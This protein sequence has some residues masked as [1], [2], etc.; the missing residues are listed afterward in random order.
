MN[1]AARICAA[2]LALVATAA[3]AP[4]G[5]ENDPASYALRVEVKVASGATLHRVDLPASILAAARTPDL[6]DLRLFDAS[7]RALP[8]ARAAAGAAVLRH[9]L[10]PLPIL[11]RVGGGRVA[12]LSLRLD[13]AG[14]PRLA[15][16]SGTDGRSDTTKVAGYLFD[17]RAISGRA[18]RLM[19]DA[20]LP[21]GQPITL[22]VEVG[23][24]LRDWRTIGESVVY[25]A[26]GGAAEAVV[27]PLG[28]VALTGDY[29]RLSW[30]AGGRL[31]A[32]VTVRGATLVASGA[33]AEVTVDATAPPLP[34]SSAIEFVSPFAVPI[35]SL[36]V[37]P[38]GGEALVPIRILGRNDSEQPWAEIGSGVAGADD[39]VALGEARFHIL[40]IETAGAGFAALPGIRFGFGPR[41]ILFLAAGKGPFTLAAGRADTPAAYLPVETLTSGREAAAGAQVSAPAPRIQLVAPDTATARRRAMLLWG[42]LLAATAALAGMAWAIWKRMP[43]APAE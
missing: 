7:G 12:G 23:A 37:M 13:A 34:A 10:R 3:A 17:A 19:L 16:L 25:R 40:R 42:I 5:T 41:A 18:V 31:L 29:L 33:A 35:A 2:L 15:T 6:D 9:E 28:N 20:D 32:P 21:A 8:V 11:A 43:P 14:Q 39:A 4:A 38:A 22:K 27:L 36:Q 30:Q 26:P 1:R 24:T